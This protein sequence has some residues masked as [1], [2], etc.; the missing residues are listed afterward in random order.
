MGVRYYI[1]RISHEWEASYALFSVGYLSIGWSDYMHTFPIDKISDGDIDEFDKF[2]S[3]VNN[4]RRNRWSLWYF[5][6]FQPGDIVVVPL[7]DKKFAVCEITE[8]P[9]KVLLLSE[10]LMKQEQVS[11]RLSNEGLINEKGE[12]Y[13]IGFV[14]RFRLAK[15]KSPMPRSYADARLRSRMKIRQTNCRADDLCESIEEALL[16]EGPIDIH[17]KALIKTCPQMLEAI[18]QYV[19]PKNLEWLVCWY[20]K[21]KGADRAEVL[22]QN[23]PEKKGYEDADVQADFEDLGITYYI[24]VKKHDGKTSDWSVDQIDEYMNRAVGNEKPD[25]SFTAIPW[26]IS[27]AD[28]YED[29]AKE[30]AKNAHI[31]LINGSEFVRMVLDAGIDGIEEINERDIPSDQME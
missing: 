27:L 9:R 10:D 3:G 30:K 21:K 25:D 16:A 13:D 5:S 6:Q 28:D 15:D 1:H 17:E 22:P 11:L 23:G 4:A 7:F 8:R 29:K 19:T 14:V 18:K 20:M 2:M 26:V 31:R 12:L 24:Q